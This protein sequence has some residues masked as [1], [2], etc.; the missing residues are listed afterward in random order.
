MQGPA[1]DLLR[2]RATALSS[3]VATEVYL[4]KFGSWFADISISADEFGQ[5][6]ALYSG[7]HGVHAPHLD[8]VRFSRR[9]D[10]QNAFQGWRPQVSGMRGPITIMPVIAA[11]PFPHLD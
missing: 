3:A 1:R 6:W 8:A 11:K 9:V 5:L 2:E 4:R 10:C 7:P